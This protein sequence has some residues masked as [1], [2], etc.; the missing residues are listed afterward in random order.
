MIATMPN[1]QVQYH[2]GKHMME[3]GSL[4]VEGVQRN[5][6]KN[7]GGGAT[8]ARRFQM[9]NLRICGSVRSD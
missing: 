2:H 8:L 6:N 5:I 3:E 7:C 1:V 4:Q 9:R